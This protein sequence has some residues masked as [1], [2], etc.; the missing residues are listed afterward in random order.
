MSDN[1]EIID[2][3]VV[4]NNGISPIEISEEMRRS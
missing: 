3:V 1:N 2:N 4:E